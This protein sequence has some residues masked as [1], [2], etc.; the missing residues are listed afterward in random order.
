MKKMTL[1]TLFKKYK[2]NGFKKR[3]KFNILKKTII[4][5]CLSKIRKEP[6]RLT[7][8]HKKKGMQIKSLLLVYQQKT[9]TFL[10]MT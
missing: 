10:S 9:K 2:M 7:F 5:E 3:R 4:L 1:T 6:S 8:Y